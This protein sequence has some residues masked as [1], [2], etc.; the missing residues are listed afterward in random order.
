MQVAFLFNEQYPNYDI[1]FRVFSQFSSSEFSALETY[2][3]VGLWGLVSPLEN[4]GQPFDTRDLSHRITK[5]F[6]TGQGNA[7][8]LA[9]S[10]LDVLL[11]SE[12]YV[13]LF[14]SLHRQIAQDIHSRLK[15]FNAYYGFTQ[16]VPHLSRLHAQVFGLLP[17]RYKIEKGTAFV[18]FSSISEDEV[19][20]ADEI[21]E[22]RTQNYG[23]V[24][25]KSFP[26][27]I[28]KRDIHLR[29]TLFDEND[30][31]ERDFAAMI[32]AQKLKDLWD[33]N[34]EQALYRLMDLAPQA[35]QEFAMGIQTLHYEISPASC[36]Q[37]SVNFRRTLE[38]LAES[39]TPP[40]TASE[41]KEAR[42]QRKGEYKY[43]LSK[44]IKEYLSHSKAYQS[45]V[46]AELEELSTRLDKLYNLGNKGIHENWLYPAISTVA[47]RLVL[48][49]VDILSPPD[50]KGPKVLF[51]PDNFVST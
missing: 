16:I 37:V 8:S 12:V 44:Y 6:V 51:D 22:W 34:V 35:W 30:G 46:E 32:A 36:A 39:L 11:R 48:L 20:V 40:L 19:A 31:P 27:K 42:R 1:D 14:E 38:L 17:V 21:V 13:V 49:L 29:F 43:R 10:D 15:Q 26:G 28:S 18:L 33:I 9:V 23:G 7:W 2:I 5:V 24:L 4:L 25:T 3:R 50:F 41:K 47:L 45:Y